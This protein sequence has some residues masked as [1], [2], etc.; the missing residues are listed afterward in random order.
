[1]AVES[2]KYYVCLNIPD[3]AQ[4]QIHDYAITFAHGSTSLRTYPVGQYTV[5]LMSFV[6]RSRETP[7]KIQNAFTQL[8]GSPFDV[9]TTQRYL[10]SDRVVALKVHSCRGE[11]VEESSRPLYQLFTMVRDALELQGLFPDTETPYVDFTWSISERSRFK[12]GLVNKDLPF[13]S[14]IQWK[15]SAM[16]LLV[17]R[18]S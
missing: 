7:A 4:Q 11:G 16:D 8:Q 2:I 3:D 1:M 6:S 14:Q 15:T 12:R 18:Q 17:E 5:Q 9:A 10:R 13:E